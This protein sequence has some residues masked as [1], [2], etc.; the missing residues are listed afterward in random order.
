MALNQEKTLREIKDSLIKERDSSIA[1]FNKLIEKVQ[2]QI[3]LVCADD[4]LTGWKRWLKISFKNKSNEEA[5]DKWFRKNIHIEDVTMIRGSFRGKRE[6]TRVLTC[7]FLR[8]DLLFFYTESW[9]EFRDTEGNVIFPKNLCSESIKD[10]NECKKAF[11]KLRK[12]KGVMTALNEDIK[13]FIMVFCFTKQLSEMGTEKIEPY[14]KE[15][16]SFMDY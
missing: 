8:D 14:R 16:F 7:G 3:D 4:Y 13:R 9:D 15:D 1:N 2:K 6:K 12:E 5:F 10:V 11:L